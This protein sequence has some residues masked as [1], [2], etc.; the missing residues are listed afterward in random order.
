MVSS[1]PFFLAFQR[2]VKSPIAIAQQKQS[3][4][5]KDR[6]LASAG[7]GDHL[8]PSAPLSKTSTSSTPHSAGTNGSPNPH[9]YSKDTRLHRPPVLHP[10][11]AKAKAATSAG[12]LDSGK[13]TPGSGNGNFPDLPSPG[14]RDED[15]DGERKL[16]YAVAIYP[17]S[18]EREDEFDVVV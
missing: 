15:M 14:F 6:D 12:A 10:I 9:P 1:R 7:K 13:S 18:S 11:S 2:D 3:Q 8:N 17:Y 16:S 4:R 5:N